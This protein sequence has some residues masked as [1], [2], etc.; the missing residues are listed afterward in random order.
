MTFTVPVTVPGPHVDDEL[1]TV[2][3]PEPEQVTVLADGGADVP[4]LEGF[5]AGH[6]RDGDI[7]EKSAGT[8]ED[9]LEPVRIGRRRRQADDIESLGARCV[10]NQK[11]K[12]A[13]AGDQAQFLIGRRHSVVQ[14]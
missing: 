11:R 8:R 3:E 10:Q 9:G 5:R 13:V 7:V 4:D 2:P 12:F 14:V 6:T 1:P